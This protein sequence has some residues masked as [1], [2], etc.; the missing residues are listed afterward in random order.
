MSPLGLSGKTKGSVASKYGS[1]LLLACSVT[2]A[3]KTGTGR[4]EGTVGAVMGDWEGCRVGWL[5]G[6]L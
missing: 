6:Y 4:G 2:T 3:V 5:E 1:F